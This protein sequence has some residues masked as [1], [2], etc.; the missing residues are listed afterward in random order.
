M[1]ALA[2]LLAACGG[3]GSS[4]EPTPTPDVLVIV[5]PTPGNPPP[6]TPTPVAARTYTVREGDSLSAIAARFGVTEAEI[7]R[8]NG[9]ADPDNIY[10]GQELVIPAPEP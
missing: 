9:I 5:T 4:S 2:V 7:Q 8:A 6:V 10:A 1:A 3:D